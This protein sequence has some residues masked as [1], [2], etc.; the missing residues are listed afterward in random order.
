M[1]HKEDVDLDASLASGADLRPNTVFGYAD[2]RTDP[3]QSNTMIDS[4]QMFGIKPHT[5]KAMITAISHGVTVSA[6]T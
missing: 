1:L 3:S 6:Q 4:Q 2:H 5:L